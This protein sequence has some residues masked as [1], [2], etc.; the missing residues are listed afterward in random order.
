[1]RL[2]WVI[3]QGGMLGSHL[4]HELPHHG[5]QV[6]TCPFNLNWSDTD[7]LF[8]Q[9]DRS[10][11]VFAEQASKF[12]QWTIFW[13]AG[14]SSMVSSDLEVYREIE[15]FRYAVD[16]VQQSKLT[17][18]SGMF[19][20]ASSAGAIYA[21]S[22]LEVVS[23]DSPVSPNSFYAFG[24]LEQEK[25]LANLS[26]KKYNISTSIFR[27]STLYGHRLNGYSRQ[28]L[29]GLLAQKILNLEEVELFVPLKTY[30]DFIHVEDACFIISD[31]LKNITGKPGN[32]IKIVA[33]ENSYS[34]EQVLDVFRGKVDKP[35]RV[36]I[37]LNQY[38]D[39]YSHKINFRSNKLKFIGE[40]MLM[41]LE[42]GVGDILSKF[43]SLK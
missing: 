3:G 25:L 10:I 32:F 27:I 19:S 7:E 28:G 24:K 17:F 9:I 18:Q 5:F 14:V 12:T 35:M 26:N 42:D 31:V 13:A 1:M 23:E 30:R 36:K 37:A 43:K 41:S 34:I 22:S 2:V 29:I 6:F 20:I 38:S 39:L 11:E 8:F 40:K 15:I 16:R 33:S 21:N 4:A